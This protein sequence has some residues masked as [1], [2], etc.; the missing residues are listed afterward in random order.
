M[1]CS[2]AGSARVSMLLGAGNASNA[3]FAAE[4]SVG[5]CAIAG[6]SLSILLFTIPHGFLP[7]LFAPNEPNVILQTSQTIPLLA[8]YV[9]ADAIQVGLSGV[10]KGCGRQWITMPIVLIAYWV[11]GV[12]LAYYLSLVRHNGQMYCDD[13]YFCGDVGLVTG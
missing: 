3:K 8:I 4:V 9:I 13:S 11:V 6:I 2:I 12:P 7:S 1:A 10:V 5:C